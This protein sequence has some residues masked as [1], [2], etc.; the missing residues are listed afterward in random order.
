MYFPLDN[1][2]KDA[3]CHETAAFMTS[4]KLIIYRHI[5]LN[6][7]NRSIKLFYTDR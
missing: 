5:G 7:V 6:L 3:K 2:Y 4:L 1:K